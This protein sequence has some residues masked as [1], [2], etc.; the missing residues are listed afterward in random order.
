M[1]KSLIRLIVFLGIFCF[2]KSQNKQDIL[3]DGKN[4]I[5]LNIN[6]EMEIVQLTIILSHIPAYTKI[7]IEGNDDINYVMSAYS[8]DKRE[9]R[10]QLGQ[11]TY[12]TS[13]LFLSQSQVKSNSFYVDIECSSNP[14]TYK[15]AIIP[16]EIIYLKEGEQLYYYVTEENVNMDFQ[17]NLESEKVNIWSRGSRDIKNSLSN[18]YVDSK[19]KN[20]FII[21]NSN[22]TVEFKITG[23]IGDLINIGSNGYIGEK[24]NK[25]IFADE[26]TM[27]VFLTKYLFPKSCFYFRTRNEISEKYYVFL[28]GLIENNILKMEIFKDGKEIE[29]ESELYIDGKISHYFYTNE[30]NDLEVCFT[31]PNEESN[32]QYKNIE[33]ITFNFHLTLGT[34]FTKG[35]N[36]NEPLLSGKLYPGNL[37]KGQATAFLLE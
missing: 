36:F 33:E 16:Q 8:D 30:L 20:H 34:N 12:K 7:F 4:N 29:K 15:I 19:N 14:C 27:T 23:T 5:T 18:F 35:I 11:S 26:E 24:S 31:F 9:N 13:T 10:I 3:F 22:K 1:K 25:E 28:E 32:P 2:L 37:R 17:I 21:S 6:D